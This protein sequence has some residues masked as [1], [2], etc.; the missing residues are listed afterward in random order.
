[1]TALRKASGLLNGVLVAGLILTACAAR[2]ETRADYGGNVMEYVGKATADILS[3][4][5]RQVPDVCASA[6]AERVSAART[7]YCV[8]PYTRILF[9]RRSGLGGSPLHDEPLQGWIE[10]QGGLPD[11]SE[12]LLLA[13]DDLLNLRHWETC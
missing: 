10:A 8:N 2:L 7:V 9:H 6:C 12:T 1:M 5:R 13:G 3:G 11:E 4:E